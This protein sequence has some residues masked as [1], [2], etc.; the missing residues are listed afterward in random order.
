MSRKSYVPLIDE[1]LQYATT[2]IKSQRH[3]IINNLLG[4]RDFCPM[5][6]KT[7]KLE[8]YINAKLTEQNNKFLKGIHKDI[9]LRTSAFLLLKDSKASFNIEGESPKSMRASRSHIRKMAEYTD[10]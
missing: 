1:K 9:L 10:T 7:P 4:V 6:T 3:L 8:Q 5:I 2:G